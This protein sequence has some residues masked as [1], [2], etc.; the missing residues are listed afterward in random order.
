MSYSASGDAPRRTGETETGSAPPPVPTGTPEETP[1]TGGEI[2]RT[3]TA[4]VHN[5]LIAGAIVLILLLVFIIENTESVKISY[6]GAGFHLP[7]GVAL[8]LAAI[9]GALVVG[10]VGTARIVQLRRSVRRQR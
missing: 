3:R 4:R 6:F 9:G 10:I 1:R 7:L 5:T 2:P 8:L